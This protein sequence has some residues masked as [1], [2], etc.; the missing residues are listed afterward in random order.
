MGHHDKPTWLWILN[1]SVTCTV[2]ILD[3]SGAILNLVCIGV[4]SRDRVKNRAS[5]LL[6]QILAVADTMLLLVSFTYRVLPRTLEDFDLHFKGNL[7]RYNRFMPGVY[8]ISRDLAAW[9]VV[10]VTINRYIAVSYPLVA[11]RF[12][13]V[14]KV[15]I[16]I[17]LL[18]LYVVLFAIPRLLAFDPVL[19]SI[20]N[21]TQVVELNLN[22]FGKSHA[23]RPFYKIIWLTLNVCLPTLLVLIF[24]LILVRILKKVN[25]QRAE[26]LNCDKD[27]GASSTLTFIAVATTF[28]ICE[29][30]HLAHEGVHLYDIEMSNP[31]FRNIEEVSNLVEFFCI[32]FNSFV[33]FFIYCLTGTKFRQLLFDMLK[34]KKRQDPSR[35]TNASHSASYV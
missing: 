33:N 25:K 2:G 26:I 11:R 15:L 8:Q 4:F 7:I 31:T 28:L 27:Q 22:W 1:E 35:S 14:R 9:M 10:L 32:N 30:P 29:L 17:L 12:C 3:I 34:C 20:D 23:Y 6:L 21:K 13:D 5:I 19:E 18:I 16:Q 24:N